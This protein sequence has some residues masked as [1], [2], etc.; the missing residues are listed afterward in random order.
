MFPEVSHWFEF[1]LWPNTSPDVYSACL[2]GFLLYVTSGNLGS[3]LE[4]E[5]LGHNWGNFSCY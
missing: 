4:G 3:G 5:R 2:K 1:C